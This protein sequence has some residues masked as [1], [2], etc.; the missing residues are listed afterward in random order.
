[1]SIPAFTQFVTGQILTA[2][3]LNAFPTAAVSAFGNIDRSNMGSAGIDASSIIPTTTPAATFG[4]SQAYTFPAAIISSKAAASGAFFTVPN[5][6]AITQLFVN[7]ATQIGGIG[8]SLIGFTDSVA[9]I[10]MTLSRAGNMGLL[11]T[12]FTGGAITPGVTAT[13]TIGTAALYSGTGSPNTVVTAPNGSLF[14]RFD[15]GANTR[16]YINTTGASS[17]GTAWTAVT[18]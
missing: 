1:M 16:L 3:V 14:M 4:G 13:G 5:A 11:G 9:G 18:D 10:A 7:T 6:T 8:A 17:S 12:L 15:G 2:T